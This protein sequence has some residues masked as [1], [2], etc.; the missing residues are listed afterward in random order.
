MLLIVSCS[1]PLYTVKKARPPAEERATASDSLPKSNQGPDPFNQ[2]SKGQG[3]FDELP[4]IP[5]LA[6]RI[7]ETCTYVHQEEYFEL[8]LTEILSRPRGNGPAHDTLGAKYVRYTLD[9]VRA[10]NIL[11]GFAAAKD[12]AGAVD[13]VLQEMKKSDMRYTPP[14]GLEP[15]RLDSMRDMLDF[16]CTR[17]AEPAPE[18]HYVNVAKAA[19]GSAEATIGLNENGT[20]ASAQAKI[21][22][23]TLETA[24]QE[25]PLEK[26]LLKTLGLPAGASLTTGNLLSAELE[27]IPTVRRYTLTQSGVVAPGKLQADERVTVGREV[28]TITPGDAKTTTEEESKAVLD[29]G[30]SI[31]LPK[32]KKEGPKKK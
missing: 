7:V 27:L 17:A 20:L 21:E 22:D 25:L 2:G 11:A 23:K 24:L 12:V 29:F 13:F 28:V 8:R 30:G 31:M 26:Y 16:R 10:E 3:P 1:G 6:H 5:F 18:R 32:E 14:P 15:A 19:A 9:P 4:G